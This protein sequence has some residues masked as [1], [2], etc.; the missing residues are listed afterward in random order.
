MPDELEQKLEVSKIQAPS[1]ALA[2][3]GVI[4]TKEDE[5]I[6]DRMQ[7]QHHLDQNE[8]ATHIGLTPEVISQMKA[9]GQASKL[10]FFDS[11]SGDTQAALQK[12][13]TEQVLIA[14]N[15]T[16]NVPNFEQKQQ[17]SESIQSDSTAP[18]ITQSFDGYMPPPTLLL[19]ADQLGVTQ[20][21]AAALASAASKLLRVVTTDKPLAIYETSL[22]NATTAEN[23]RAWSDAKAAFPQLAAISGD[24]MQAYTRNE[25]ASYDRW[26]LK[27]DIDAAT[28]N[29]MDLPGRPAN[30][31]TL[32]I[33]QISPK[34]VHEFEE[35]YPQLKK[36]LES[37]G[38]S[39]ANHEAAALLDPDCVPMIVATKT[40]SV[41]EDLHKHGIQKPTS[42]QIAY[43]YNPDVYSYSN[44]HDGKE[45]KALYQLDVKVSA[46]FHPDQK[47]EYYANKPEVI[48]ASKHIHNVM[49]HLDL[50]RHERK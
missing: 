24:I 16:P 40:A 42:E 19:D 48:A 35:K 17:H 3:P 43:A 14:S 29:L 7:Q 6:W 21:K 37:K 15:I 4:R 13:P 36:F 44:G 8:S 22:I 27:E 50:H 10:E 2:K 39:G 1:D 47:K 33:S 45:Y 38:Y 9:K 23:P 12:K 18:K 5:A 28:N 20:E 41:V 32:G 49:S 34:G 11:A 26:D 31:A 46:T 25:I 30:Q